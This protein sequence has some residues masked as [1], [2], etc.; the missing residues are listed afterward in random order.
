M[1]ITHTFLSATRQV[2]KTQVFVTCSLETFGLLNN[3]DPSIVFP[4]ELFP[5]L[6]LPNIKILKVES[7]VL[8][9][10]PAAESEKG[11]K[12]IKVNS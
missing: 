7:A 2:P 9:E 8:E 11:R 4:D 12:W 6:D 1:S 3:F 10:G 5:D